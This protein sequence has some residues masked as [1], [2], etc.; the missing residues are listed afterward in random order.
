[1]SRTIIAA[2][3]LAAIAAC[4]RGDREQAATADSLSRD[5]Q[6]APVDT[7]AEL[8]DR[9]TASAPT[10]APAPRTPTKP[11]RPTTSL[12]EHSSGDRIDAHYPRSGAFHYH[13]LGCES[14]RRHQSDR[15]DHG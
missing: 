12:A 14:G 15:R 9:P 11:S 8:N 1:M 6:L 2:L 13:Q 5:L 7:T 3:T 10:P 4:G